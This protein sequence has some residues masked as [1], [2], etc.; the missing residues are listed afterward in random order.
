MGDL[1]YR[2]YGVTAKKHLVLA[3]G[4]LMGFM[5]I[6][7][8]LYIDHHGHPSPSRTSLRRANVVPL[9][10]LSSRSC[11]SNHCHGHPRDDRRD[12]Q[13]RELFPRAA[14]QPK[15]E[16]V[17]GSFPVLPFCFI[18]SHS[19]HCIRTDR[20]RGCH[21]QPGRSVVCVDVPLPAYTLWEDVLDCGH[22][23]HCV[24]FSSY[25]LRYVA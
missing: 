4:V 20:S 15:V 25:I 21:G 11:I 10:N 7:L 8:G 5:S 2:W 9:L 12:R 14:L 17:H 16:R 23:H 22:G 6:A 3:C 19:H 13:R 24:S 18:V 1:V